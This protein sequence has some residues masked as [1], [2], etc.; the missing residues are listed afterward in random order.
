VAAELTNQ[1]LV[2]YSRP[3]TLVPPEKVDVSVERPGLKARARMQG[4]Q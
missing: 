3:D 2:V 1:Y 4:G